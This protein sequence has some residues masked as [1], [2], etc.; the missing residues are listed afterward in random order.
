MNYFEVY[1]TIWNFHKKY[2]AEIENTE[3][4]WNVVIEEARTIFKQYN[5]SAFVKDLLVACVNEMERETK[6]GDNQVTL[7]DTIIKKE[8]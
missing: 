3:Q 4:F 7:V 5:K 6:Q 2:A 8:C 1:K